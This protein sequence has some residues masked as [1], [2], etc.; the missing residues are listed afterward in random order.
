M[1]THHYN[2]SIS[3]S[4]DSTQQ[5]ILGHLALLKS[6]IRDIRSAP[7]VPHKASN[8]NPVLK[9]HGGRI[10]RSIGE[11]ATAAEQ[12][13]T[14]A[15]STAESVSNERNDD[16]ASSSSFR[17]S[18]NKR[19][20]KFLEDHAITTQP[21]SPSHPWAF[22]SPSPSSPP[23]AAS[24]TSRSTR[25]SSSSAI[26]GVD[27]TGE[28][29]EE[30]NHLYR[31]YLRDLAIECIKC[32]DYTGAIEYLDQALQKSSSQDATLD[33]RIHILTALCHIFQGNWKHAT[34]AVMILARSKADLTACNLL[35][36]LALGHLSEFAFEGALSMCRQAL[37]GKKK[38]CDRHGVHLSEYRQTLALY[39]EIFKVKGD[40]VW[41]EI[42]RSRLPQ[43]FEYIHPANP[44]S[45]VQCQTGVLRTAFGDEIPSLLLH[46]PQAGVAELE[47]GINRRQGLL[48]LVT[49]PTKL[50]GASTSILR[51][52]MDKYD[53]DTRK[54]RANCMM[55]PNDADDEVSPSSA[56]LHSSLREHLGRFLRHGW[57]REHATLVEEQIEQRSPASPWSQSSSDSD[58]DTFLWWSSGKKYFHISRVNHRLRKYRVGGGWRRSEEKS[59]FVLHDMH[60]VSNPEVPTA[61]RTRRKQLNQT[62]KVNSEPLREYYFPVDMEKVNPLASTSACLPTICELPRSEGICTQP[63][64]ERSSDIVLDEERVS[65]NSNVHTAGLDCLCASGVISSTA[66]SELQDT[67]ICELHDTSLSELEDISL[68]RTSSLSPLYNRSLNSCPDSPILPQVFWNNEQKTPATSNL[69]QVSPL[70]AESESVR[71]SPNVLGVTSNDMD[72]LVRDASVALSLVNDLERTGGVGSGSPT[73]EVV[74][75]ESVASCNDQRVLTDT[76]MC[77]LRTSAAIDDVQDNGKKFD[78]G[79]KQQDPRSSTEEPLLP[80]SFSSLIAIQNGLPIQRGLTS[81]STASNPKVMDSHLDL[82]K[83][84]GTTLLQECS[85]SSS[86]R[87]TKPR[88]K[89]PILHHLVIDTSHGIEQ[90]G[91]SSGL[92][93]TGT[94]LRTGEERSGSGGYSKS[95]VEGSKVEA[96]SPLFTMKSAPVKTTGWSYWT[97]LVESLVTYY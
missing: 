57:H 40:C 94:P 93:L 44:A 71:V 90:G 5:S 2:R 88:T 49:D 1:L 60:R 42:I 53:I 95:A 20:Q 67:S 83:S 8:R 61:W 64:D 37:N 34:T 78:A 11:L 9:T 28:E 18:R 45:F 66:M 23:L 30:F 12:L 25:A 19:V 92:I 58:K 63:I 85:S 79:C 43:G 24:A 68:R 6:A 74:M 21:P 54:E 84:S 62:A 4:N 50:K 55:S 76:E 10:N 46:Y 91:G 3:L 86:V 22:S 87:D 70:S 33:R 72:E 73:I 7:S 35:H 69:L 29:D 48:P 36:A 32:M 13:Y 14:T 27:E 65:D 26:G 51:Q 17:A 80:D 77:D 38:L 96:R 41:E 75:S 81:T 97:G 16:S 82:S 15:S 52:K 59:A 89:L 31:T 56:S 47:S 39:A